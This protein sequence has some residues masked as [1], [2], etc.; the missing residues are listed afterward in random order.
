[1][2]HPPPKP[3][4]LSLAMAGLLATPPAARIEQPLKLQVGARAARVF[5]EVSNPAFRINLAPEQAEAMAQALVKHA[6][7]ARAQQQTPEPAGE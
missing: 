2:K 3:R 5:I 7:E 4:V 6:A 1:M